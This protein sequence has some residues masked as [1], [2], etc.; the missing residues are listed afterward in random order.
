MI[1]QSGSE[2]P[3]TLGCATSAVPPTARWLGIE[4]AK[5]WPRPADVSRSAAALAAYARQRDDQ[6]G[7]VRLS[8]IK[9]RAC[10]RIGELSGEQEKAEHGGASG[11]SKI[12]PAGS[13]RCGT[14]RRNSGCRWFQS[15]GRMTMS[16]QISTPRTRFCFLSQNV[17]RSFGAPRTAATG[18]NQAAAA[19][20]RWRA[21]AGEK[22]ASRPQEPLSGS[23]SGNSGS[24]QAGGARRT[25]EICMGGPD[26][27]RELTVSPQHR[28]FAD[29]AHMRERGSGSHEGGAG[30][31][32]S[33]QCRRRPP[34]RAAGP[35]GPLRA[36]RAG[37]GAH[38]ASGAHARSPRPGQSASC[39]ERG[40]RCA[41]LVAQLIPRDAVAVRTGSG[42]RSR[43][44]FPSYGRTLP[45]IVSAVSR[46]SLRQLRQRI[47][48]TP[49]LT[50]RFIA[51]S[52]HLV[53]TDVSSALVVHS[54]SARPS[55]VVGC[56]LATSAANSAETIRAANK[57]SP[58]ASL[59]G[60]AA[61]VC[62]GLPHP[63]SSSAVAAATRSRGLSN[64][65][66]RAAIAAGVWE[67][68]N[69]CTSARTFGR[70][71]GLPL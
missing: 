11:G 55:I 5:T 15:H 29:G 51:A 1:T 63:R 13:R 39:R 26:V 47:A 53:G 23:A 64:A 8:E 12:P 44:H 24:R 4:H 54:P 6:E 45:A 62:S 34:Q 46:S 40:R 22:S 31:R 69:S 25:R 2:I 10:I 21:W 56:R 30:C 41:P 59:A 9:L 20:A 35:G 58:I 38:A 50:P 65:A 66:R 19:R 48:L 43:H 67:R 7:A 32:G 57:C 42:S 61:I 16:A 71:D 18:R 33:A 68:A 3:A 70:P 52:P 17:S 37:R 36:A 14:R 28:F 60:S 27:T 49:T